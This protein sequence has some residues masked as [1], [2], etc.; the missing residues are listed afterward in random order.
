[1]K[2]PVG[3]CKQ[4]LFPSVL[5]GLRRVPIPAGCIVLNKKNKAYNAAFLSSSNLSF[6]CET[7][8]QDK[9]NRLNEHKDKTWHFFYVGS[10]ANQIPTLLTQTNVNAAQPSKNRCHFVR[11]MNIQTDSCITRCLRHTL[12][13]NGK[14]A[15][16]LQSTC[17]VSSFQTLWKRS[18]V[19]EASAWQPL[20]L[21]MWFWWQFEVGL[22]MNTSFRARKGVFQI[23]IQHCRCSFCKTANCILLIYTGPNLSFNIIVPWLTL[24]GS[25]ISARHTVCVML[26][27]CWETSQWLYTCAAMNRNMTWKAGNIPIDGLTATLDFLCIFTYLWYSYT[28]TYF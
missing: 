3:G 9:N 15:V 13:S 18:V 20:S 26:M 17:I 4:N 16:G 12:H 21:S 10:T 27:H 7:K 2:T 19:P 6:P 11:A 23:I 28:E 14:W 24:R 5:L 22:R 8:Q 1:M 25:I